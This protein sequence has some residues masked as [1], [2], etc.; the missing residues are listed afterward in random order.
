MLQGLM[1]QLAKSKG[2]ASHAPGQ[3]KPK[4]N[5]KSAF[6]G[7]AIKRKVKGLSSSSKQPS[8]ADNSDQSY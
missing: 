2:Q 5:L 6:R 3:Q 8:E 7:L 4:M 1:A